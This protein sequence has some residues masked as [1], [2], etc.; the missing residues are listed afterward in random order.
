MECNQRRQRDVR[1][2][3]YGQPRNLASDSDGTDDET[4]DDSE[5]V[6]APAL[7]LAGTLLPMC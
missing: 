1:K 2:R 3:H 4:D 5:P 7:P 6:S